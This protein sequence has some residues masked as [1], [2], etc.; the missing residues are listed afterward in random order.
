MIRL[1][2]T[3]TLHDWTMAAHDFSGN[4]VFT[5]AADHE[6]TSISEFSIRLPV[7]NLKSESHET[8]KNAYKVLK[9]DEYKDILFELKSAQFTASGEASYIILLH[10][11]LTIAGVTHATTLRLSAGIND[12]GS[13]S[14]IGSLPLSLSDYDIVRP[15]FLLGT[16][17]IGEVLVM[18]YRL[19]L[20]R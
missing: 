12:D 7:H 8:E 20:I 18:T 11:Q 4:A 16:M 17:K 6:L 2:G 3:S 1:K 19:L 9:D 15:T 14:C 10:G 5:F 13:I